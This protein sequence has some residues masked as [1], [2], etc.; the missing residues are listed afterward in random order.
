[1]E[2]AIFAA[3]C[4]WGVE[5]AFSKM[6]GVTKTTVGY[7]DG[8]LKEP[9]YEEVCSG[10][11]GHA[12]AI[13]IEFNPRI[14]KYSELLET[15][16]N[17]HDPTTLNRQGLDIGNQY[18]SAIFFQDEEQK[19]NALAS[20]QKLADSKKHHD[21]IVTDLRA[22]TDFYNAEEY[23]QQYLKKKDKEYQ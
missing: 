10:K 5:A 8:T 12:E 6:K 3:G 18:R 14:V 17:I 16:W 13:L 11:T 23:H 21:P 1:M 9:K 2:K 22:A 7:T 19:E 4:F 20:I 15:F